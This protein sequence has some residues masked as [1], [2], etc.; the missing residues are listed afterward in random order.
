[1]ADWQQNTRVPWPRATF[2]IGLRETAFIGLTK[3]FFCLLVFSCLV[4]YFAVGISGSEGPRLPCLRVSNVLN[5]GSCLQVSVTVSSSQEIS[6]SL[7][8][9]A[10]PGDTAGKTVAEVSVPW[11][12]PHTWNAECSVH[13]SGSCHGVFGGG[14]LASL[15]WAEGW[16]GPR[17]TEGPCT[18]WAQTKVSHQHFR[19]Q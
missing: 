3:E 17:G 5:S 4:N 2:A 12:W 11:H 10:G 6:V 18:V 15:S 16:Q 7:V 8:H 9:L 19:K 1:M 14:A 13:H